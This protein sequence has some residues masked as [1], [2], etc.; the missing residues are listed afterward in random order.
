MKK[1]KALG[2]FFFTISFS[3]FLLQ[4]FR[5][6]GDFV[7]TGNG[8]SALG[9]ASVVLMFVSLLLLTS[10]ESLEAIVV[11][12]GGSPKENKER[13]STSRHYKT[14]RNQYFVVSGGRGNRPLNESERANIYRE[15]RQ[16]E[17]LKKHGRAPPV[18]P[19][20][21]TIEGNSRDTVEN[22]LY[23]VEKIRPGTKK[24]TF[25]SYPLHLKRFEMVF[26]KAKEEG[27]V[28]KDLR[29]DYVPTDQNIQEIVYGTLALIK[30]RWRLRNGIKEAEKHKTGK[31]GNLIKRVL[32]K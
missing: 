28:P 23:S 24:I 10:K 31:L 32:E 25:V 22:V 3:T 30:E 14:E 7:G 19:S 17:A 29:A 6:T 12:T 11:P 27:L 15:L 18:K 20:Q 1:R 2:F 26:E 4:S 9:L 21:M 8:F 5:M 13:A 16:S